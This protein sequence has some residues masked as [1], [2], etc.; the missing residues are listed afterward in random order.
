MCALNYKV[1]VSLGLGLGAAHL[2][3]AV[4]NIPARLVADLY[5]VVQNIL[6]R[7]AADLCIVVQTS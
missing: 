5:I 3:I 1:H 4:Q 2:C 7:L 6:A